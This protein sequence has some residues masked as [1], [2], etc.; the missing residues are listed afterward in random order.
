MGFKLNYSMTAQAPLISKSGRQFLGLPYNRQVGIDNAE[1]LKDDIGAF[2][3]EEFDPA[4]DGNAP[5]P[6]GANFL[7]ESGSGY[8]VRVLGDSS[9]I[10]V[11]SHD[12]SLEITFLAQDI[13]VSKTGRSRYAPPYHGV[14]ANA[15]ELKDE[16][17]AFSIEEFDPETDGNSPYPGGANFNLEPGNCYLVRVLSDTPYTP[18][19]Y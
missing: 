12:P 10:A 5:Y 14:A 3:I 6:G 1:Q 11:G 7:L 15:E 16:I 8:L 2:S 4:T 18:A 17:G 19:H 9:Y 13:G